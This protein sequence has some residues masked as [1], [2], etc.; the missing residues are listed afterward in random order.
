MP[1][2]VRGRPSSS[3]PRKSSSVSSTCAARA[4][5]WEVS[6]RSTRG[7]SSQPRPRLGADA[8]GGHHD[9]AR[10]LRSFAAVRRAAGLLRAFRMASGDAPVQRARRY[11]DD[12][13]EPRVFGSHASRRRATSRR[14]PLFIAVTAAASTRPW[15]ATRPDGA[16][17]SVTREIPANTSSCV[18]TRTASGALVAYARAMMFHGFPMVMEY[19]Y[20]PESGGRDACIGA[21]YRRG[22]F[23]CCAFAAA[24]GW[25]RRYVGAAQSRRSSRSGVAGDSQRS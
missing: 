17:I 10:G 11:T 3:R 7:E 21:A 2:R 12:A 16:A 5:R 6:V 23:G 19:G 9:G 8:I 13:H 14:S 20:A 18:A 25:R 1:G 24:G 15:F 22:G 4:F